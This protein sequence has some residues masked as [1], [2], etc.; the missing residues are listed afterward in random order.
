MVCSTKAAGAE[1]SRGNVSR[2]TDRRRTLHSI[3]A[4][5]TYENDCSCSD[6]GGLDSGGPIVSPERVLPTDAW[7]PERGGLLVPRR[8][9]ADLSDHASALRMRSDLHHER[10]WHRP[11]PGVDRQGPHHVRLFPGGQPAHRLRVHPPGRSEE[12]TSEL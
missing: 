1:A 2:R 6:G 7:R 12:H 8:Q 5:Y 9:A 3:L 11:A 10:G 4:P